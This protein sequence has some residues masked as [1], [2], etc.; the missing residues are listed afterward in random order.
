MSSHR[1]ELFQ[2]ME[3][4]EGSF[5]SLSDQISDSQT[6]DFGAI[7]QSE[8]QFAHLQQEILR[9]GK[10]IEQFIE[11]YSSK[12]RPSELFNSMTTLFQLFKSELTMNLALRN[13]LVI[14]RERR[15]DFENSSHPSCATLLRTLCDA[16]GVEIPTL[17]S[18][19]RFVLKLLGDYKVHISNTRGFDKERLQFSLDLAKSTARAE[20]A[21]KLYQEL[22]D[23]LVL[24]QR[25]I[26]YSNPTER[27]TQ[28]K[29]KIKALKSQIAELE[30][31]HSAELATV[32][33]KLRTS[34]LEIDALDQRLRARQANRVNAASQSDADNVVRREAQ[35]Q[36]EFEAFA[37]AAKAKIAEL[38][39]K[40]NE[41]KAEIENQRT[42]QAT[43]FNKVSEL[44]T[45]VNAL[46]KAVPTARARA[47]RRQEPFK[48][49]D[50]LMPRRSPRRP[51]NHALLTELRSLSKGV[52][53]LEQR[54]AQLA[55][56][57]DNFNHS[58]KNVAQRHL[59][60]TVIP[61]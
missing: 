25:E 23:R 50:R 31:L 5:T 4:S 58:P 54:N 55:S 45:A 11:T 24:L 57:V 6:F 1:R 48:G 22:Q 27:I 17:E 44:Q 56:L 18:A 41:A 10:E 47:A 60:A 2:E 14:M 12:H 42:I 9:Q 3:E 35:L 33:M 51:G 37:T 30:Q 36:H 32:Q 7:S 53:V 59:V 34:E 43:T 39:R 16:S 29:L 28:K 20:K 19:T 40:R 52:K 26:T 49:R 21:E 38:R 61:G 15:I 13:Q 8:R 46:Q